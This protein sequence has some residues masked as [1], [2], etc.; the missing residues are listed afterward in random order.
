MPCYVDTT[1]ITLCAD[2]DPSGKHTT[3]HQAVPAADAPAS[4]GLDVQPDSAASH[5]PVAHSSS[6]SDST[7]HT[8]TSTHP[9]AA[10][11]VCE[12]HV[13]TSHYHRMSVCDV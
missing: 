12:V 9:D 8:P 2:C 7:H 13:D 4:C 1:V 11:F 10:T 6:A 3:I 5:T